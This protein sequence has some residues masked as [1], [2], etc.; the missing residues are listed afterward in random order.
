MKCYE[1]AT[2]QIKANI[3]QPFRVMLFVMLYKVFLTFERIDEIP[4]CNHS[5]EK[6][7]IKMEAIEHYFPV[8][9]RGTIHYAEQGGSNFGAVDGIP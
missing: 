6:K 4:K 1:R 8:V 5:N 7:N 9:L 2:I 3:G